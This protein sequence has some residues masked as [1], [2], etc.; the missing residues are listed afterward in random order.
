MNASNP[1]VESSTKQDLPESPTP[2]P[3]VELTDA[4]LE[5]VSGGDG[6]SKDAAY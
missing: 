5:W 2:S 1:S 6:S 3:M 4:E